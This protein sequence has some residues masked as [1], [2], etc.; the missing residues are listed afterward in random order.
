MANFTGNSDPQLVENQ[1][2]LYAFWS[3]SGFPCCLDQIRAS[4]Y[5]G[6][7]SSPS[8]Q[9]VDGGGAIGLNRDPA[10]QAYKPKVIS[11]N[12]KLYIAWSE[13][14]V[15]WALGGGPPQI[16]SSVYNG[17][18]SAPSWL[19]LDQGGD[20]GLNFNVSLASIVGNFAVLN[21]MLFLTWTENGNSAGAGVRV[22][23][24]NGDDSSPQF[25]FVDDHPT[26]GLIQDDQA[27][28]GTSFVLGH[29]SKLLAVWSEAVSGFE[30]ILFG[31][32][33]DF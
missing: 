25:T 21:S 12:S 2:K 7:D 24:F 4:V 18:E 13:V 8:W 1:G 17:N 10:R 27:L 16:R 19:A 5:N 14:N 6:N 11:F 20:Q 26:Q 22:A 9:R 3:E 23:Q 33:E 32:R 31:V 30:S 28:T 15:A 29:E